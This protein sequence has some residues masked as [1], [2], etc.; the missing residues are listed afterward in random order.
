MF[1]VDEFAY[2][3]HEDV[4]E[5]SIEMELYLEKNFPRLCFKCFREVTAKTIKE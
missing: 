1:E 3:A 2:I 5:G 4:F